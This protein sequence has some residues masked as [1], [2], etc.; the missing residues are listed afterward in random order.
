MIRIVYLV[1]IVAGGG[2]KM[3]K[4]RSRSRICVQVSY[5]TISW[6]CSWWRK[7]ER[8]GLMG[9]ERLLLVSHYVVL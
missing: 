9:E 2:E 3:G 1:F 6:R 7:L 4:S 5:D 8:H